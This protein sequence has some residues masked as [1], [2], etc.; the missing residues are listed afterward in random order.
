MEKYL[1]KI[2]IS[3]DKKDYLKTDQNLLNTTENFLI[4]H[5]DILEKTLQ[6]TSK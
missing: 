3:N 1:I 2:F 6:K 4:N 5:F